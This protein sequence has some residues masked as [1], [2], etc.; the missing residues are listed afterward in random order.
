V[1]I[2]ITGSHGL[3]GSALR[4]A[5]ERR[6]DRVVPLVRSGGVKHSWDPEAGKLD[7]E[8]VQG[9]DAVIHL[10]GENLAAGRWTKRRKQRIRDSRVQ[11][12]Q[13]LASTLASLA[14][15]PQVL[16]CASAVGIYGN[17]GEQLL[18]EESP[19][20]E[21][22]LASVCRGWEAATAPAQ[23][24]GIR[25]VSMRFGMILSPRGGALKK[26]LP[27]FRMGLGAVFG[28]GKQCWSWIS[29]HDVL[30]AVEHALGTQTL[31]G[32]VNFVS[33][34]PVRN[35]EFTK[36]LGH[37]LGR[38]AFLRVPSFAARLAFGEMSDETLLASQRVSPEKL[39]ASGYHFREA[40]LETAL[41]RLL[42]HSAAPA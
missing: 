1:R 22:F 13:L 8:A 4:P 23:S 32:P 25:V 6:G 30:G 28:D 18:T 39:A 2:L 10:A 31:E 20:G 33:P 17:R 26:M 35:R 15:R 27:I 16:L 24:R 14:E 37:L 21:G 5:L 41:Q 3:V 12:T 36:T 40:N 11:A 19:P 38:P 42:D 7:P 29:I 9:F 34:H